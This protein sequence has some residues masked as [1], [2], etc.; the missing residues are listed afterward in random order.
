M[1]HYLFMYATTGVMS[2]YSKIPM[3]F[4]SEVKHFKVMCAV[5]KTKT[6]NVPK[7]LLIAQWSVIKIPNL[8]WNLLI[9][10]NEFFMLDFHQL[11]YGKICISLSWFPSLKI[12][13][14]YFFLSKFINFIITNT[15]TTYYEATMK[16]SKSQILERNLFIYFCTRL[17]SDSSL[18]RDNFILNW[19]ESMTKLE[20]T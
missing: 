11:K 8:K 16:L 18:S 4:N 10:S 17:K 3:F 15:T 12:K 20:Q 6:F 5:S 14:M 1:L 7:R 19:V 2:M 9:G 13:D